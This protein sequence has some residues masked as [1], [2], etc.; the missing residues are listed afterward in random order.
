MKNKYE[1]QLLDFASKIDAIT[2]S[3]C[4]LSNVAFSFIENGDEK[5][6][7]ILSVKIKEL[8]EIYKDNS[9]ILKMNKEFLDVVVKYLGYQ[10]FQQICSE[11]EVNKDV[12]DK[13]TLEDLREEL[14]SLV[15][16]KSVKA[17]VQN[18][19]SYQRILKLRD[20]K[21]LKSTKGTLHLSFTGN[22][23]SGKTTVARIVGRIYKKIGLLSKGHFIEVSRT[24][25][26]AGF[27]GQTALKVKSVIEKAKGGVLFIDEAYSITENDNSDSYGKECL[28]E[29][30]KALE[31]YREDLVVIVA[32]YTKPMEKFFESNPGLKSRFNSFIE[33]NDY[34]LEELESI[35]EKM[36][37]QNDYIIDSKLKEKIKEYFEK[38][39]ANKNENF[40]NGRLVRN[41]YEKIIMNQAVRLDK[42]DRQSI[43]ELKTLTV[44][45]FQISD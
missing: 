16:L 8:T 40:S 26:I 24:D 5:L 2:D 28:T 22:P 14:D 31:D 19:I 15:G 12:E 23:G 35:F 4:E 18:L 9:Q 11:D 13:K 21:N 33:F 39:I 25:L 1:P 27:Q 10:K 17:Q 3:H 29:L 7:K 44:D 43:D 32:G 42:Q 45:D 37:I 20:E 30:T 34:N 41:L 38:E 36:C 6:V